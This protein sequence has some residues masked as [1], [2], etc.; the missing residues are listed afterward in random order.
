MR[1]LAAVAIWLV[2]SALWGIVGVL[3]GP[4]IVM[5]LIASMVGAAGSLVTVIQ[6]IGD[7]K[8]H[9]LGT[10]LIVA[11]AAFLLAWLSVAGPG[12]TRPAALFLALFIAVPS[13]SASFLAN[14]LTRTR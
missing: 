14:R 5:L 6:L 12:M 4:G 13:F 8:G 9:P 2:L 3:Y 1:Y 7:Y 10:G 11:G